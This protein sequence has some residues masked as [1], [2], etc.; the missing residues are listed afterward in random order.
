[1]RAVEPSTI[2]VKV[3]LT[4]EELQGLMRLLVAAT[5]NP[6]LSSAERSIGNSFWRILAG[7]R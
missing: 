2:T 5:C 4:E 6:G 3:E 1:M 7:A